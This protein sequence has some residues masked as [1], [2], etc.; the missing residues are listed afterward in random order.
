LLGLALVG[1][2]GRAFVFV[3][4]VLFDV[5]DDRDRD[6]IADAHLTSQE[7]SDLCAADIVLDKLLDDIDVVFPWLKGC[8][9]FVDVGSATFDDE[10]LRLS[11]WDNQVVINATYPVLAQN[12]IQILLTPHTR[13]RHGVNQVGTGQ[14]S[15]TNRLASTIASLDTLSHGVDLIV[16]MVQHDSGRLVFLLQRLPGVHHQPVRGLVHGELAHGNTSQR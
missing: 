8:E 12:V 14:E 1:D 3:E 5:V 7:Q 15:N 6:Q 10:G 4:M 11:G 9:G 16:N 2:T 13:G